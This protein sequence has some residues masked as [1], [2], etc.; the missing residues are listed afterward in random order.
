[1]LNERNIKLRHV[2]L[3]GLA[4]VSGGTVMLSLSSATKKAE[5][6]VSLLP[7]KTFCDKLREVGL[8]GELCV[9]PWYGFRRSG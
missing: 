9:M 7:K 1:M 4:I 6:S 8:R 3:L 2:L 5:A